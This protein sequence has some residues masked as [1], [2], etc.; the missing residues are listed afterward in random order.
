[1]GV[2]IER[3]VEA[4]RFDEV[5]PTEGGRE[6]GAADAEYWVARRGADVVAKLATY[7]VRELEASPASALVGHYAATDGD[8]GCALLRAAALS[9][10]AAGARRVFGPMNG[11]TWHRYR[12]ALPPEDPSASP[13]AAFLGEPTNPPRYVEDFTGA[14]FAP[15]AWYESTIQADL[16]HEDPRA[17]DAARGVDAAGISIA[18]LRRD[19]FAEILDVLHSLSV[20]AFAR[21]FLY[22][23]IDAARFRALYEP[24]RG[25]LHPELVLLARDAT[26]AIVGVAFAIPD[27]VGARLGRAGRVVLKTLAVSP[28]LRRLGLGTLLMDRV[29]ARSLEL[30][31]RAVIHALMHVQN[32]SRR[33]SERTS[34]P[35]RRYALLEWSEARAG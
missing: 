31:H 32:S 35:F 10:H 21:N 34:T 16:T 26:D 22:S 1:M 28:A 2:R 14:G 17:A 5:L 12:L 30:G 23:P 11:S 7:G 20:T 8:A 6:S 33:M 19:R 3:A 27:V 29:R 15:V 18:P 13:E 9:L 4:D 24:A 25:I